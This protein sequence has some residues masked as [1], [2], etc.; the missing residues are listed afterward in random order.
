MFRSFHYFL[1][2]ILVCV[3]PLAASQNSSVKVPLLVIKLG[4]NYPEGTF[5]REKDWQGLYCN[6]LDCEIR[7]VQ[8]TITTTITQ[9]VVG[10][11]EVIDVLSVDG[12][13]KYLAL[14]PGNPFKTG[15]IVT[16][17][18]AP[19]RYDGAGVY[20]DSVFQQKLDRLGKSHMPWGIMP[21]TLFWVNTG[22]KTEGSKRFHVSDGLSKQ[23]L[24]STD[25]DSHYGNEIKPFVHWVGDLDRDGKLDVLLTVSDED[26]GF[27]DRLYLSSNAGEKIFRKAAQLVGIE[28]ACGC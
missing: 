21:L 25:F 15:K 16:W 5:P 17:Y 22:V 19:D 23:F 6:K 14:F 10:N 2:G 20:H 3:S 26:C 18:R 28:A 13:E 9:N 7:A 1:C 8:V 27:D 24:F 4:S 12:N 11:D